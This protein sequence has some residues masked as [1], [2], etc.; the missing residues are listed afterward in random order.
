MSPRLVVLAAAAA[1]ARLAAAAWPSSALADIV[2]STHWAPCYYN[3]SAQLPSLLDGMA[4]L[5]PLGTRAIKLALDDPTVNYPWL[6]PL[7]PAAPLPSV[8]ALAAHPYY[9]AA[10]SD[11]AYST[12]ALIT[13]S[14]GVVGPCAGAAYDAA[15]AAADTAQLRELT[16]LLLATYPAKTFIIESW[17]LDWFIRCGSFDPNKPADPAVV[18]ALARWLTARQA[19]VSAGRIAAC[20]ASGYGAAA[21]TRDE[22]AA[23]MSAAGGAVYN[24]AEVNLVLSAMTGGAEHLINTV[25]PTIPLDMI[26]YSS[27]DCMATRLFGACLD[28]IARNHLRTPASPAVAIA[29]AEFGVPEMTEPERVLPVIKNVIATV[30]SDGAGTPGVRRAAVAFYWELFNNEIKTPSSRF[31]IGRCTQKSGP[32]FDPA[33]QNGFWLIRPNMT[34]TPGWD[35][36]AGLINGSIPPPVLKPVTWSRLNNSDVAGNDGGAVVAANGTDPTVCELPCLADELCT[37]VVFWDGKCWLK[38]GGQPTPSSGRVLLAI[39]E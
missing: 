33:E 9:A 10:L 18:G 35:Y 20:T 19:G 38:Y 23:F 36:F 6:S 4:S 24:A 11:P 28:Y 22:G 14:Q 31:P 25:I 30:L 16:E 5:R 1:A 15:A 26:T 13:Y 17:E 37:A 34:T 27:Y 7:W 39:N 21:C 12:M 3:Q 32:S 8:A 29:I 2:S